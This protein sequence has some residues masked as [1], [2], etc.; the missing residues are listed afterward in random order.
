MGSLR[1]LRAVSAVGVA[2]AGA[3]AFTTPTYASEPASAP[4]AAAADCAAGKLCV[5]SGAD[6]QGK[7]KSLEP[8]VGTCFKSLDVGWP[9]GAVSRL[10]SLVNNLNGRQVEGFDSGDCSGSAYATLAPGVSLANVSTRAKSLRIAPEC[11]PGQFCLYENADYTGLISKTAPNYNICYRISERDD[12]P[13]R[14]VY[15]NLGAAVRLYSNPA[16]LGVGYL[17]NLGAG[18]FTPSDPGVHSIRYE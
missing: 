9:D 7:T 11:A 8:G 15:N 4:A 18:Q 12:T 3:L 16:C 1:V 6:F 17:I 2:L 10:G 13:G 5:W 14:G